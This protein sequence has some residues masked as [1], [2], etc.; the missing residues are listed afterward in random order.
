MGTVNSYRYKASC[1]RPGWAVIC[2]FWHL[3]TLTSGLSIKSTQMGIKGIQRQNQKQ[4]V[5]K[6]TILFI[7]H[8]SP[9]TENGEWSTTLPAAKFRPTIWS[10]QLKPTRDKASITDRFTAGHIVVS[11]GWH[12]RDIS[13]WN[14]KLIVIRGRQ[15]V[16]ARRSVHSD[17]HTNTSHRPVQITAH[18]MP[19]RS[20]SEEI[21][22]L[23]I[24]NPKQDIIT[25]HK[26]NKTEENH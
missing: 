2:N 4:W 17:T 23:T 5:K 1:A 25:T 9:T 15:P 12:G 6:A 10:I 7:F 24:K 16:S 3:G 13:V 21:S 19:P 14:N 20:F 18:F 11:S 22:W 26:L 8:N